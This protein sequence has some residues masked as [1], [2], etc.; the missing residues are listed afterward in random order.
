MLNKKNPLA[1]DLAWLDYQ[2]KFSD[3]YDALNYSK[4][5]QA[6]AMRASHKLLEKEYGKN[7]H[8]DKVLEIGGGTGEHLSFVQHTFN[9]YFLTDCNQK[10]L[11]IAKQTLSNQYNNRIEFDLQIGQ[12][13]SYLD[14]T[15]DRVVASHVLEHINEPHLVLKEWV[16]VLKHGG[17]LSIVIPTDPGLAWRLGKHFGPRKNAIAQGIA[18]DYVMAREHVNS[19]HNLIAIL[20][21]YF[22]KAKDAWWP[23][24]IPSIDINLFFVCHVIVH[25]EEDK[26]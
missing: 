14:N 1:E 9:H 15:F 19:C 18:Y 3:K 26:I 10:M 25:K 12:N 5:V 4:S 22:P 8:F 17:V 6:L 11:D 21:H 2:E 13:L 7:V 23:F 20:R 24:P 16:R